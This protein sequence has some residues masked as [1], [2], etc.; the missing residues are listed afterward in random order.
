MEVSG[1][2]LLSIFKG[3]GLTIDRGTNMEIRLFNKVLTA[4]P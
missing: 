1:M 3:V 4:C 2:R